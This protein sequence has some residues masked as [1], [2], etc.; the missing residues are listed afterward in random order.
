M[1]NARAQR[2]IRRLD[3][4][5]QVFRRS[6]T[7]KKSAKLKQELTALCEVYEAAR[8]WQINRDRN[9]QDKEYDEHDLTLDCVLCEAQ[10]VVRK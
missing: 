5:S 9:A 3:I 4:A 1:A 6:M 7:P 2:L 10:Q 8:A